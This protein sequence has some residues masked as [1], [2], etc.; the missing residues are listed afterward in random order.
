MTWLVLM[1]LPKFLKRRE[2]SAR[3]RRLSSATKLVINEK[4]PGGLEG[5]DLAS[6]KVSETDWAILLSNSGSIEPSI[7]ARMIPLRMARIDSGRVAPSARSSTILSVAP[8]KPRSV[9]KALDSWSFWRVSKLSRIASAYSTGACF[10][11]LGELSLRVSWRQ[12]KLD[13]LSH[14]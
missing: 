2:K 6:P 3:P 8:S 4:V 5:T 13:R 12:L 7:L 14:D 10:E 1:R 9:M 11:A